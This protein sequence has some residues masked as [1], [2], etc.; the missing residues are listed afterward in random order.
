MSEYLLDDLTDF[1]LGKLYSEVKDSND[2]TD[3]DFKKALLAKLKERH[4]AALK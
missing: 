4:L 2:P 3:I 1:D